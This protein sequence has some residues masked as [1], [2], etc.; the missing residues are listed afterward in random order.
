MRIV[1]G[2]DWSGEA[3]ATRGTDGVAYRPDDAVLEHG[4]GLSIK[5]GMLNRW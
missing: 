4:V 3:F 2:V 1:V 5:S